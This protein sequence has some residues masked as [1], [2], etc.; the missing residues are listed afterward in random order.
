M[1]ATVWVTEEAVT[2]FIPSFYKLLFLSVW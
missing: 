2:L 1:F